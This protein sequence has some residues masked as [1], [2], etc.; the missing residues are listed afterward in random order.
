MPEHFCKD[1][2]CSNGNTCTYTGAIHDTGI[3]CPSFGP[4]EKEVEMFKVGDEVRVVVDEATLQER[5]IMNLSVRGKI[6]VVRGIR[7]TLSICYNVEVNIDNGIWEY[8]EQDLE[9]VEE[10]TVVEQPGSRFV[11]HPE[12]VLEVAGELETKEDKKQYGH[13]KFYKML[14]AMADLYSRKNHDY[15]GTSDPLKNLRACE[16]L[17]LD[18]F[19]GVMVRLQ[20]KWSRLEEFVKSGKLMVKGESVKDTLMDNAVYSILAIILYEEQ[21][22]EEKDYDEATKGYGSPTSHRST[23]TPGGH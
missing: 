16:R 22:K 14:E 17:E 4:K 8:Y 10:P 3:T 7:N 1:C 11:G 19:M 18:P 9:L 13:P 12:E 5:G 20:D 2:K 21:E 23:P 6:G 15:A